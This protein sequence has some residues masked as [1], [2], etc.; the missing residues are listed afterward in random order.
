MSVQSLEFYD[1]LGGHQ[2]DHSNMPGSMNMNQNNMDMN[3]NNMGMNQNNMG[4]D[5][6]NMG[7]NQG[8]MEMNQNNMN[9]GNMNQDFNQNTGSNMMTTNS[10]SSSDYLLFDFSGFSLFGKLMISGLVHLF[11]IIIFAFIYF[12]LKGEENF[13]GLGSNATFLDCLYFAMTTSSTVGYGDIAPKSQTARLLV[14]VHQFI[15]L[16]EVI[17]TLAPRD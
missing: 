7:M 9:Q 14:M 13:E 6:N 10:R 15:V 16:M 5:Q 2:G 4:M 1:L 8:N 11:F 3:Q 17:F 12:S